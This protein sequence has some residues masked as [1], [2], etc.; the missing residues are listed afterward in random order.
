MTDTNT[1]ARSWLDAMGLHHPLVIAGPC[2]AET[3]EQLLTI[4][5]ALRQTQDHYRSPKTLI[6]CDF[7][8]HL[9]SI[10]YFGDADHDRALF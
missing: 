6:S 3:E 8:K 10:F 9:R 4:A 5:H 7:L 1:Q 2:S